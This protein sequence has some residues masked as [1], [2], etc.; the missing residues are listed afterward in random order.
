MIA[1][2]T[3]L[4]MLEAADP[5]PAQAPPPTARTTPLSPPPAVTTA[6]AGGPRLAWPDDPDLQAV[7]GNRA[8]VRTKAVMSGDYPDLPDALRAQGHHGDVHV[9]GLLSVDGKLV[10]T[11]VSYSSGS[12]E[13]DAVALG[14]VNGWTWTPALD[15]DGKPLAVPVQVKVEF[16]A[17]RSD[18]P[19]GGLV[20]YGCR[21]FV[22]DQDWWTS[23][24]P[25]GK[26]GDQELYTL[27]LGLNVIASGGFAAGGVESFKARMADFE[28]RWDASITKCRKSPDKRFIDMMQPEGRYAEALSKKTR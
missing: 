7:D 26:R 2:L 8:L 13:L 22:L 11:R 24:H 25:N 20:R 23:T 9:R 3:A 12:P 27:M 17:Y 4:A 14:A 1:I 18:E 28:R 19:G 10:G 6:P 21:Q 15:A 16:A 5:L